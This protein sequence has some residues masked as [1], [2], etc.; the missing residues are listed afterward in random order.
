MVGDIELIA[1]PR[2]PPDLFGDIDSSGFSLI[3]ADILRAGWEVIK[4]GSKY[5]QLIVADDVQVDLFLQPDPAT[6][7]I[8]YLIRT[9]P[10]DFSR[11]LVT[12]SRF[13]GALPWGMKVSGGRLVDSI[14]NVPYDTPEEE[15]VF[16][17]I[18]RDFIEVADREKYKSRI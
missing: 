8:N 14:S 1:I 13:G 2:F 12:P 4:D 6:W 3:D 18:H 7:G 15:D 16:R 10:R 11:W 17:E 5:K 9:G